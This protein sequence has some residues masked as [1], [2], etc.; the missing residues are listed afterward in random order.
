[1]SQIR[2]SNNWIASIARIGLVS[3]GIVYLALGAMA[4]MSAFELAGY[5]ESDTTKTGVFKWMQNTGGSILLWLVVAGL[6]CYCG[7]RLVQ[8]FSKSGEER[9]W[10]KRLRYF[11]SALAYLS[12]AITAA[13][14][15]LH[16]SNNGDEGNEHWVSVLLSK[17]FGRWLVGIAAAVFAAI[18]CYQF[19]YGFSG[20]Y[21]KH[22]E[23]MNLHAASSRM[24][25]RMGKVGYMARG[26]VWLL[27]AFLLGRAAFFHNASEAGDTSK[28]FQLVEHA[29]FGSYILG[30][31]C[32]G[33]IAYG[34]FNFVR[35][36]YEKFT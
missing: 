30:A 29:R 2:N 21:K 32:L 22:L 18:G 13:S 23:G 35:A 1:M 7:W 25:L 15:A 33:L 17:P 4:F 14:L 24:L 36:R 11:G 6:A 26:L 20:K 9:K 16:Q 34:V 8:A 5:K 12:I 27:L 31:I 19:Y 3:K 28:A 10:T